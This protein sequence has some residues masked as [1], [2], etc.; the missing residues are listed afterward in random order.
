[1][2]ASDQEALVLVGRN[3]RNPETSVGLGLNSSV[4]IALEP[5]SIGKADE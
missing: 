5:Q 3:P 4:H 2:Y 1:M